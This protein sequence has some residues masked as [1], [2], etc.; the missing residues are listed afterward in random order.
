M[1][2][3]AT[4]RQKEM[5]TTEFHLKMHKLTSQEEIRLYSVIR[6]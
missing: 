6:K 3:S 2:V 1:G 4:Q 5:L